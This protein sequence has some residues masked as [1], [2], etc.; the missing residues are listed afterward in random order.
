MDRKLLATVF[1]VSLTIRLL[2]FFLSDRPIAAAADSYDCREYMQLASNMVENAV[3]SLAKEPPFYRS[4]LR[5]P[6]Y[7]TFL[8]AALIVTPSRETMLGLVV[9]LQQVLGAMTAAAS[10]VMAYSVIQNNRWAAFAGLVTGLEPNSIRYG[11]MAWTETLFAFLLAMAVLLLLKHFC[12]EQPRWQRLFGAGILF[13]IAALCRPVGQY[14]ALFAA[15]ASLLIDRRFPL[16][17]RA[18]KWL[19]LFVAGYAIMVL[20]WMVRNK[21]ALG[22]F[23]ISS[24]EGYG[25][26]W[27]ATG[28]Q[29]PPKPGEIFPEIVDRMDAVSEFFVDQLEKFNRQHGIDASTFPEPF[30]PELDHPELTGAFSRQIANAATPIIWENFGLFVKYSS[31]TCLRVLFGFNKDVTFRM[32]YRDAPEQSISEVIDNLLK[33]RLGLAWQQAVDVTLLG[34]ASLAWTASYALLLTG[35]GVI[36]LVCLLL[37]K[38]FVLFCLFGTVL[39]VLVLLPSMVSNFGYETARYRIPAIPCLAVLAA[40]TGHL[41]WGKLRPKR[42]PTRSEDARIEPA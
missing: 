4:A 17:L 39:A 37:D 1:L 23:N 16:R 12:T 8:A 26:A 33:G 13:G 36:G 30:S 41:A 18:G 28:L 40:Y 24:M 29:T 27:V 35:A 11:L 34:W 10:A 5:T 38:R 32:L 42:I 22:V 6:T 15:T 20:P 14:V 2:V 25:Q 9:L 19:A 31:L 3:F 21:I 7:P